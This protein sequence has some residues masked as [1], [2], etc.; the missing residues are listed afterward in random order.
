MCDRSLREIITA[1]TKGSD[2]SGL[3]VNPAYFALGDL[4]EGDNN[5]SVIRFYE[6]LGAV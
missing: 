3:G 2:A 5:L 4:A 1:Q 6:R